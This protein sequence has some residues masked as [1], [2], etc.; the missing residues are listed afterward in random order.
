MLKD[1][2]RH[3]G[4]CLSSQHFREQEDRRFKASLSYIVVGDQT[5]YQ[6]TKKERRHGVK[7][8]PNAQNRVGEG[9]YFIQLLTRQFPIETG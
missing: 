5:E 9:W 8:S 7:L 4:A 1:K 3:K 2:A 6:K